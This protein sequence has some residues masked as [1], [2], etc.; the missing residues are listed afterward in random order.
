MI[1]VLGIDA[2]GTK[3]VCHL[4]DEHGTLVNEARAG[5]AN[6]Q[7]SGELHVEKVI[8]DVMEDAIGDRSIVPAAICLGIAGVDRPEDSTVV[9]GIMRRIGYKARTLVLNDALVALEAGAPGLPGVVII[10]GTGSI[11]YGRNS[12]NEGARAGGW[13][14]VL[15]DE[16]S[17][18]WIGRASLRAVLREADRRGPRTALTPLLLRHFGVTEAQN[19]IHEVY[20]NKLRPSAI[21]ALAQCVQEAFTERDDV[22]VGILRG[23]ADE[24]EAFG[25]S[26]AKRLRL[27]EE[28]FTFILGGGIFR[29][30]PWLRDELLRR[31]PL[32]FPTSTARL[33]DCEPAAGA[34][35]FALAEARGGARI[36]V[37]KA[38]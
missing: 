14:H 13:G 9:R 25:V 16:G 20:Q 11:A 15:G 10:S 27:A 38:D 24:L 23:A 28:P 36:P 8:H 5:G 30:V 31:L 26:V 4:A 34:V 21:G 37:Y 18:Y 32:A 6:L 1:H 29:A 19:L 33:L 2:G 7:A 22:A 3:T 12:R 35:S 17:G